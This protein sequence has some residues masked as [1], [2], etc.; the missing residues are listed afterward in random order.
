[1]YKTLFNWRQIL[2]SDIVTRIGNRAAL[3]PAPPSYVK[4]TI[5]GYGARRDSHVAGIFYP[6]A[7]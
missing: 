6:N 4:G 2:T 3:E 1:M 5:L 7:G